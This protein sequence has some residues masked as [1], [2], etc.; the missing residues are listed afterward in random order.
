MNSIQSRLAPVVATGLAALAGVALMWGLTAP[1]QTGVAQSNA[2]ECAV[3]LTTTDRPENSNTAA[4]SRTWYRSP[5][6]RI[7]ASAPGLQKQRLDG[8]RVVGDKVLWIK[9][10]GSQL[11]V[12][13]RRLDGEAPPLEVSLPCC[14][15]EDFQ[16]S[17]VLF[18][19]PGCCEIEAEAGGTEWSFIV[20]VLPAD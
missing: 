4:W 16:A 2:K 5:D 19:V 7:W 10:T 12:Q 6:S 14:Y 9:P 3:T 20:Q 11:R 15:R 17:G 13:G 18:P 1:L 8:G